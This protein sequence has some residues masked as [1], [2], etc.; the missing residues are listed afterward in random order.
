LNAGGILRLT[1]EQEWDTWLL[2]SAND[3][4]ALQTPLPNEWLGIVAKGEKN[5]QAL[6][7][8]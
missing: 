2:C 4:L 7:Y 6:G 8:E 5:D 3:A 1:T